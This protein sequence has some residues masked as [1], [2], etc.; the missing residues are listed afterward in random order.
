MS[1]GKKWT[2]KVLVSLWTRTFFLLFVSVVHAFTYFKSA[3][4]DNDV[5]DDDHIILFYFLVFSIHKIADALNLSH[6]IAGFLSWLEKTTEKDRLNYKNR[7]LNLRLQFLVLKEKR[8][9][10]KRIKYDREFTAKW[11]FHLMHA[12]FLFKQ[13]N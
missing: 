4:A 11:T 9:G 10:K 5:G 13:Q 7:I 3:S 12:R 2:T 1:E 8:R 6:R